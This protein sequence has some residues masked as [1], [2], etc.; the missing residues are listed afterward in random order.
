MALHAEM[1]EQA[2][3]QNAETNRAQIAGPIGHQAALATLKHVAPRLDS[4]PHQH[5]VLIGF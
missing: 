3:V 1:A 4:S 2:I 5:V